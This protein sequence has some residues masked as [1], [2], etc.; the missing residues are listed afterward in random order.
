[1]DVCFCNRTLSHLNQRNVCL[2]GL[3]ERWQEIRGSEHNQLLGPRPD[4]GIIQNS[5]TVPST[6]VSSCASLLILADDLLYFLVYGLAENGPSILYSLSTN[7][8]ILQSQVQIP[9]QLGLDE[10]PSLD[11]HVVGQVIGDNCSS[12]SV[13]MKRCDETFQKVSKRHSCLPVAAGRNSLNKKY[14][15]VGL[16]HLFSLP[17]LHI[18]PGVLGQILATTFLFDLVAINL[19][20]SLQ[21]SQYAPSIPAFFYSCSDLQLIFQ[22]ASQPIV[23][24]VESFLSSLR[25]IFLSFAFHSMSPFLV[26]KLNPEISN[27]TIIC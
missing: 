3:K 27:I 5:R 13:W 11:Q 22:H 16:K 9:S 14:L 17:C 2:W 4:Y 19:R 10:V 26:L 7:A 6:S 21:S 18:L 25:S 12:C 15:T 8:K 24:T 1:M 20:T 23:P